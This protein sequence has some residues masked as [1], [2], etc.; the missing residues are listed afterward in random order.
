MLVAA[1]GGG[2]ADKSSNCVF[3]NPRP[4][5]TLNGTRAAGRSPRRQVVPFW[6]QQNIKNNDFF[7]SNQLTLFV[8][9]KLYTMNIIKDT[10][11]DN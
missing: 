5:R 9:A 3:L 2:A 1:A 7:D 8:K 11:T 4:Q 10:Y 6:G